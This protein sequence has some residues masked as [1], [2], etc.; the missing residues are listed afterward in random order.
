MKILLPT[1]NALFMR[2]WQPKTRR[3][4]L[5]PLILLE[6]IVLAIVFLYYFSFSFGGNVEEGFRSA[7]GFSFGIQAIVLLIF[8]CLDVGFAA[9]KEARSRAMDSHRVSGSSPMNQMLG[10]LFGAGGPAY[11]LF[12]LPIP[13]E[14]YLATVADVPFRGFLTAQVSLLLS[15]VFFQ[16]ISALAGFQYEKRFLSILSPVA[17]LV[18]VVLTHGMA[19]YLVLN[20]DMGLPALPAYGTSIPLLDRLL[21]PADYKMVQSSFF[22]LTLPDLLLQMIIQIPLLVVFAVALR[23]AMRRPG[24]PALSKGLALLLAAIF[25]TYFASC[26]RE[27]RMGR[28][29]PDL[30]LHQNFLLFAFSLGCVLL[31]AVTPGYA[32]FCQALRRRGKPGGATAWLLD[33]STGIAVWAIAYA[34]L[35]T[36]S[37]RLIIFLCGNRMP[38]DAWYPYGLRVSDSYHRIMFWCGGPM[39]LAALY[40]MLLYF[41]W[42]AVAVEY[43]RRDPNKRSALI[44]T[45]AIGILW[46]LIPAFGY[47]PRFLSPGE[48][49]MWVLCLMSTCPFFGIPSLVKSDY[50]GG[51]IGGLAPGVILIILLVN[52]L[53]LVVFICLG[54][55]ARAK[56]AERIKAQGMTVVRDQGC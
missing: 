13:L 34:L 9:Y 24:H 36:V 3:A 23:R 22:G 29:F 56:I 35:T 30:E 38:P 41:G 48:P 15:G 32:L 19:S 25:F 55:R 4:R 18:C 40:V 14:V 51:Y 21:W 16:T 52:D 8:G 31:V 28:V 49:P 46:L 53:L 43:F 33:D 17:G 26:A 39:L 47:V 50:D 6:M 7:L 44:L 27:T 12:V 5:Y 37:Y 1:E 11:I 20:A 45:I 10:L 42:F 2:Y 54:M